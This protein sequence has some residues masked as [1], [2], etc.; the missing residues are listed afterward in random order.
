MKL[1]K[2]FESKTFLFEFVDNLFYNKGKFYPLNSIYVDDKFTKLVNS[3]NGYKKF[4]NAE[5]FVTTKRL[6]KPVEILYYSN[7]I[8]EDDSN[9]TKIDPNN[10]YV[11]IGNK[12]YPLQG[13]SFFISKNEKKV[14]FS[15]DQKSITLDK[16]KYYLTSKKITS[17]YMIDQ[18]SSGSSSE[19]NM[20]NQMVGEK[21]EPTPEPETPEETK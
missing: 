6:D 3:P 4:N 2:Y 20:M 19:D 16:K 18:K 11:E 1:A 5:I 10:L 21:P 17:A 13:N 15:D 9:I 7:K 8:D 14:D 12:Y